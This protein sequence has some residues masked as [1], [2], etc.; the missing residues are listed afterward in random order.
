MKFGTPEPISA[1]NRIKIIESRE[2]LVDIRDFCPAV[3]VLDRVCPYLRRTAA[4]MLNRAAASLPPGCKFRIGTALR[5]LSM[6]RKGWDRFFRRTQR[7][8]PD[9]SHPALRRATN[10]Y[11]A[12]YDQPA[13]PGHCTGGA[14][15]VILLGPDRKPADVTSPSKRWEAAYTWSD[16]ISP[17]A[18]ANRMILVQAMLDAGFSNC[19]DEYW[20][21]SYGDSG[22]AVR[23]GERTCPYGFIEPS[24]VVDARYKGGVAGEITRIAESVWRAQA[25]KTGKLDIGVFWSLARPI[26]LELQGIP[27]GEP[28]L[29]STNR[30]TWQRTPAVANESGI[31]LTLTPRSD[32]VYARTMIP[33]P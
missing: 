3:E 27:P 30:K 32:R 24:P 5:T 2:P 28:V 10:K 33:M 29:L 8:H 21:Y 19:R 18:K 7:E 23:V 16:Y 9:W 4:D 12:P 14:V 17:Q 15:D 22:W 25:D 20:H 6:Q 31:G 13:P 11:F 26:V 1:L